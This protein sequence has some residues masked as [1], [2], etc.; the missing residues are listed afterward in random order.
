MTRKLRLDPET[1]TVESFDTDGGAHDRGTVHGA[2]S[3]PTNPTEP[4]H[5]SCNQYPCDCVPTADT[6][7]PEI[8]YGMT[9]PIAGC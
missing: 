5:T 1:L 4:T 9:Q 6:C 7:S 2:E 8:C 3:G